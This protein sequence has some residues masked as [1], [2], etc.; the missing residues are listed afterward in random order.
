MLFNFWIFTPPK[1]PEVCSI[2]EKNYRINSGILDETCKI[3]R[4]KYAE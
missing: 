1:T 4:H 3:S 2:I